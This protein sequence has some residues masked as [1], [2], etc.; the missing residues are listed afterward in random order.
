M[1]EQA[2]NPVLLG[3]CD[4]PITHDRHAHWSYSKLGGEPVSFSCKYSNYCLLDSKI[5]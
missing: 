2:N 5:S 4:E 3:I 1:A